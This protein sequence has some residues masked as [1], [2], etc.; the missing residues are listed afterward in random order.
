M[1]GLIVAA[2]RGSRME[3]FTA[4]QPKCLLPM[5]G[6]PL[7]AHTV[8]NLRAAGCEEIIVVVGYRAESICIPDIVRVVNRDYHSHN[9]LHS[10]M[11]ARAYL[12]GPLMIAYADIWV[13]PTIYRAL[14]RA[15][16]DLVI[17]VDRDWRAYYEGRTA[18]PISE[19][20]KV[21]YDS[22]GRALRLGKSLHCSPPHGIACGEFLGLWRMSA[23]GTHRFRT[24]FEELDVR[25]RPE[26]PFQT[27]TRWSA[28]YVTDMLQ[29]LIDRG[30]EIPCCFVDRGWAELDTWQDY[31]RLPRVAA[32]QRLW[33]LMEAE[34]WLGRT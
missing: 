12:E 21:H 3:P 30:S 25:L 2:G 20:E 32:R 11:K 13:E 31:E 29:E 4:R 16:G 15:D 34:A 19:A 10:L 23:E 28:A 24:A 7:L 22:S 33:A 6:R 18:H 8:D 1:R 26:Q 5:A 9:I 17:A 27:A 14:A